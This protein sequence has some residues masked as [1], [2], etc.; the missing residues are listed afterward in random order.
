ME[1][2]TKRLLTCKQ[3]VSKYKILELFSPPRVTVEARKRGFA[4]T[5]PSNFDLQTGWNFFDARDRAFF[6][7]VMPEQEPDCVLMTPLCKPFSTMMESNWSRM[8]CEEAERLQ[9]AGLA[10]LHFCVQVAEFQLSR[11]K[12]FSLEQPGSASSGQTH[13]LHWLLQQPGVV[14]FLFDQCMTGLSV[15]DNAPSRKTTSLT[16]NHLGLA[17]TF[18]ARQCDGSHEHVR[19]EN[20]LPAKAAIFGPEIVKLFVKALSFEPDVSCFFGEDEEEDLE[21]AIDQAIEAGGR[22]ISSLPVRTELARNERLTSEQIRKINQVHVNL[23]HISRDQMLSLFKA[24]GAKDSV[25]QYV[26]NDY[27]CAQCSRQRKPVERKK[28]TMPRTFAFNRHV[29]IDTFYVAWRG[30]THAFMNVICHGTNYQ[31]V[32]WLRGC[33]AGTPPSKLM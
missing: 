26:K 14:R 5:E 30:T 6:W 12:E 21:D 32:T 24:A 28:A 23:G 7:Q 25:M 8:N 11:G 15:K 3:D 20:G 17:A 13:A 9:Q 33:E 18:S 16:T 29:G 27:S 10:M 4:V 22:P 19:L 31:Q 2:Q 1:A